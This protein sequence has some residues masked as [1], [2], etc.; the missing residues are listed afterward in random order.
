VVLIGLWPK[1]LIN[2]VRIVQ[3]PMD[4]QVR[5]LV[6]SPESSEVAAES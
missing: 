3:Q 4:K 1:G 2:M 6:E 5:G